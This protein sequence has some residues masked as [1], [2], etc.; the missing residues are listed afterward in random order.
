MRQ[1]SI[2]VE[3]PHRPFRS[4]YRTRYVNRAQTSNITHLRGFVARMRNKI[5]ELLPTLGAVVFA[6]GLMWGANWFDDRYSI[7]SKVKSCLKGKKELW[8]NNKTN[9]L[10]EGTSQQM[11]TL[12]TV[13]CSCNGRIEIIVPPN[14]QNFHIVCPHCAE[15]LIVVLT[16]GKASH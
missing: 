2:V 10:P 8:V 11:S 16:P 6:A 13:C 12:V 7:A 3:D 5:A 4:G 14:M 9:A 1:G 15:H